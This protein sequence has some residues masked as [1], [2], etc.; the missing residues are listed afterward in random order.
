MSIV[1]A[2]ISSA[3]A[4]SSAGNPVTAI[5]DSTTEKKYCTSSEPALSIADS[6]PLQPIS[7]SS[8]L[9]ELPA[10]IRDM[11]YTSLLCLGT[12]TDFCTTDINQVRGTVPIMPPPE[13]A[14]SRRFC[15]ELGYMHGIA[16]TCAKSYCSNAASKVDTASAITRRFPKFTTLKLEIENPLAWITVHEKVQWADSDQ[17]PLFTTIPKVYKQEM[18]VLF[19]E[20]FLAPNL[21][22]IAGNRT[23]KEMKVLLDEWILSLRDWI[24]RLLEGGERLERVEL[25]LLVD[26]PVQVEDLDRHLEVFLKLP[27]IQ[28]V[29]LVYECHRFARSP[30]IWFGVSINH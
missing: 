12:S 26:G 22:L 20:C 5:S 1:N 21:H 8:P 9:F 18:E 3:L 19:L 11:I 15:G 29:E 27:C 6:S 28:R 17:Y 14:V 2:S 30:P 13:R 7:K 4:N 16:R 10:E 25:R 24:W 23:G